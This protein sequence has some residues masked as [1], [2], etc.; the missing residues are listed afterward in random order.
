MERRSA[1]ELLHW[2]CTG[3]GPAPHFAVVTAHPDDETI[4]A[5][6]RLRRLREALF[7]CVTDGAPYD[8]SDAAAAGYATREEY[9]AARR[10][11]LRAVFRLAGVSL[12]HLHFLGFV[13]QEASRDMAELARLLTAVLREDRPDAVLTHPY[14]GGHPDHDAT[15]L[16]TYAACRILERFEGPSPMIFEMASYHAREETIETGDFLPSDGCKI[17]TA[18][19]SEEERRFK[20]CLFGC[21]RTQERV[22]RDFSIDV[23][24]FRT[25]PSYD[26]TRPPHAGRL[27]YENFDRGMT[28]ARWRALARG[29]LAELQVA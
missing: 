3:G 23:E 18:V 21:Y 24:R 16:V 14:E 5:G 11:E 13:D 27:Y 17:A 4:G 8:L 6:G 12:Q 29:A 28:G 19:L 1:R 20:A 15:A 9:A 22:L 2:L 26:F 25:A 10:K 7:V